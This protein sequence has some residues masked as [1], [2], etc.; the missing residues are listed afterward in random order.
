MDMIYNPIEHAYWAG[1]HNILS[2]K[3][4]KLD[5]V[6]TWF[7]IISLGLSLV[8]SLRKVSQLK[9]KL[10]KNES[11]KNWSKETRRVNS[12]IRRELLACLC[13]TLDMTY[14]VSYLPHGVLW[15]GSLK[16]WQV[17]A[18]GTISSCISLYQALHKKVMQKKES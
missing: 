18:L 17:G 14:A 12:D 3:S 13:L 10:N 16:V 8:K 1:E 11:C 7:W 4:E 15:G 6:T 2:I 9:L 5:N